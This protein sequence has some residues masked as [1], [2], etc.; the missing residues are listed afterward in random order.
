[1]ANLVV[2][3]LFLR[4]LIGRSC[5]WGALDGVAVSLGETLT[6]CQDRKCLPESRVNLVLGPSQHSSK[7]IF[8]RSQVPSGSH[9]RVL[10]RGSLT[11][12]QGAQA[13]AIRKA[14]ETRDRS[15]SSGGLPSTSSCCKAPLL[16]P[17]FLVLPELPGALWEY[18]VLR[19][20][21]H[22]PSECMRRRI[23][24]TNT[25]Y[26]LACACMDILLIEPLMALQGP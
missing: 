14:V 8:V 2:F 22:W 23:V 10:R 25:A 17:G 20:G 21:M 18:F 4:Y 6:F 11:E 7:L 12:F 9:G 19:P 3:I 13:R 5:T 1:M 16:L 15:R 24:Q 26:F